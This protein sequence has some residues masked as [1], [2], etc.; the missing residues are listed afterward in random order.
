MIQLCLEIF[1]YLLWKIF[2]QTILYLFSESKCRCFG[3]G[4][5]FHTVH[6]NC[7]LSNIECL[8]TEQNSWDRYCQLTLVILFRALSW[9]KK[10][11]RAMQNKTNAFPVVFHNLF[12]DK[13][14]K[15]TYRNWIFSVLCF[16]MGTL[17]NTEA[18]LRG[19]ASFNCPLC[20]NEQV[21]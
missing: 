8:F 12:Q 13:D 16:M 3:P 18:S 15:R 11:K 4:V 21:I 20:Y 6:V 5:T 9:P 10:T 1:C 2:P 19:F 17:A 7:T 14:K